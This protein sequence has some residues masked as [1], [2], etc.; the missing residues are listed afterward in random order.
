[1]NKILWLFILLFCCRINIYAQFK[2]FYEPIYFNIPNLYNPA[3][4]APNA[5]FKPLNEFSYL[6]QDVENKLNVQLLIYKANQQDFNNLTNNNIF[7]LNYN[8]AKNAGLGIYIDQYNIGL[9]KRLSYSLKYGYQIVFNED[10]KLAAGFSIGNINHSISAT[11]S[12]NINTINNLL[13]DTRVREFNNNSN[14]LYTDFGI[15][16]MLQNLNLQLVKYNADKNIDKDIIQDEPDFLGSMDYTIETDILKHKIA[17]G[18]INFFNK[19]VDKMFINYGVSYNPITVYL[20]ANT[21]KQYSST[22]EF[23]INK[24]ILFLVGYNVGGYYANPVNNGA[25]NIWAG[26]QLKLF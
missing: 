7:S 11:N 12:N 3:K 26:I 16:L 10:I 25:G 6:E 4:I 15:N 21:L 5:G 2:E 14:N 18:F 17:L 19:N 9:F 13:N 1:M 24:N 22:I 23:A 20:T 8:M